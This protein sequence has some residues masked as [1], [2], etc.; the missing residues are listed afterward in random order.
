MS[1]VLPPLILVGGPTASGKTALGVAIARALNGEVVS[2]DSVQIFRGV[3]IGA[4]TP[5]MAERGGVPHHLMS[6]LD[7]RDELTAADFKRLA[8]SAIEDIR[9]REKTP[10]IVGGSGLYLKALLY[11]LAQAPA[12]DDALRSALESF[13]DKEGNGA[14]WARL[15]AVDPAAASALHPNDR[16]RIVR[17]LEVKTL[18]GASITERQAEHGFQHPRYRFAGVGLSAR[19][20]WIH[21]RINARAKGMLAAGLVDEVRALLDDGV[22]PNA[23]ALTAIGLRECVAWLRPD[24]EPARVGKGERVPSNL[25][26]LEEDI[27][28]HT[29]NFARRQ[30]VLFRKEAGYRW[31][32]AEFL[33]QQTHEILAGLERF[34]Q[35][36]PWDAGDESEREVSGPVS[37]V[38]KSRV[39]PAG[40]DAAS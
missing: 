12:R 6:R 22:P 34:L 8:D 16:V 24:S 14:L 9:S 35:G 1:D 36:D 38:R 2:A 25:Q 5:S 20:E 3:E 17:A 37:Q 23:Q 31:F 27:A 40:S 28:T 30:L 29:R 4:A 21:E 32:N 39:R 18:T 13:A 11:G 10:I 26:E 19:R 33:A 7:P 15:Q